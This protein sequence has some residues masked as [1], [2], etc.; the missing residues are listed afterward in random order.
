[1]TL[2][3]ELCVHDLDRNTYRYRHNTEKKTFS[4]YSSLFLLSVTLTR[5]TRTEIR[6][7]INVW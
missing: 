5:D 6:F 2:L 1:M 3:I 4:K 7:M